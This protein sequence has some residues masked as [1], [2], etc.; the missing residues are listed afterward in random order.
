MTKGKKNKSTKN[1]N[2]HGTSSFNTISKL[3]CSA[4][5]HI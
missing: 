1:K 3:R 4:K 2:Q 5:G